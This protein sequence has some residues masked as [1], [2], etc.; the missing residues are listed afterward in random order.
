MKLQVFVSTKV[1]HTVD[2][3]VGGSLVNWL[4][5][6]RR[7]SFL[8]DAGYSNLISRFSIKKYRLWR[9]KLGVPICN[10]IRGS[11]P[12]FPTK[13]SSILTFFDFVKK[14]IE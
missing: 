4:K 12:C 1:I 3:F 9:I 6:L 14:R 10:K 11:D 2:V 5:H 8:K 7:E 13:I